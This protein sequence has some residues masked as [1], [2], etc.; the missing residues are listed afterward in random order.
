M[1]GSIK[2]TII[3]L[4][5][6]CYVAL[7]EVIVVAATAAVVFVGVRGE[8]A[9][10]YQDFDNTKPLEF[11]GVKDLIVALRWL[12]DVEGCFFTCSCVDDQ[13]VKCALNLLRL[14]AKDW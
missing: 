11:D 2:T 8:R 3:E 1:L 9:F 4:F 14:W 10:R 7:S 12:Y 13:K 5:D 6:D